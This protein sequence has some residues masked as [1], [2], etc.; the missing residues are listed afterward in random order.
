MKDEQKISWRDHLRRWRYKN[1]NFHRDNPRFLPVLH[2]R[3]WL[4]KSGL[5]QGSGAIQ[6]GRGFVP[7]ALA[8]ERKKEK[9]E[10][11]REKQE[12]EEIERGSVPCAED[13]GVV[14]SSIRVT[15]HRR[16]SCRGGRG[17]ECLSLV[18][19]DTGR[20]DSTFCF[21]SAAWGRTGRDK[22][23]REGLKNFTANL[24]VRLSR[25]YLSDVTGL[26]CKSSTGGD[27]WCQTFTLGHVQSV[28]QKQYMKTLWIRSLKVGE[29]V[30]KFIWC[31][32]KHHTLKL[33]AAL[34]SFRAAT[35][36]YFHSRLICWLFY[37]FI[38][39][40]FCL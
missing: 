38:A 20:E 2:V 37:R 23:V 39:W 19:R 11:E 8:P 9:K 13:D 26:C 33:L 3:R 28:V 24:Q 17:R 7:S 30:W 5:A 12:D 25:Q 15:T 31:D 6:P 21:T 32:C 22:K 27:V 40:L 35:N 16:S 18:N 36:Y 10:R 14:F 4:S 34:L 29:N 1:L